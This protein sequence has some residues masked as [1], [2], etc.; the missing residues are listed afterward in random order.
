MKVKYT[1][2]LY[3]AELANL[4]TSSIID[5]LL[6]RTCLPVTPVSTNRR[7]MSKKTENTMMMILQ[8]N[9]KDFFFLLSN[10]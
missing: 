5:R 3:F 8:V 9:K 4:N 1:G 2:N 10:P 6:Q 7:Q